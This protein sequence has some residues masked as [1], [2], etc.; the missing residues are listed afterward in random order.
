MTARMID[1]EGLALLAKK[2][3]WWKSPE[4][5]VGQPERVIALARVLTQAEIGQFTP[6]S[7]SYWHYR[8]GIADIDDVPALP[9]RR[10]A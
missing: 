4:D 10:L 3:V 7:W 6:R 9:L 8:L 1:R 2:Y 5:A